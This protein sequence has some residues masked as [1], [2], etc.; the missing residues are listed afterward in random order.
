MLGD[1][2]CLAGAAMAAEAKQETETKNSQDLNV[3][4]EISDREDEGV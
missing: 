3:L 2:K 4:R 1:Y